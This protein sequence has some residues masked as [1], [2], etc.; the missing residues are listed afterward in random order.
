[1]IH[2]KK[3]FIKKII[4]QSNQISKSFNES[5]NRTKRKKTEFRSMINMNKIIFVVQMKLQSSRK[6]STS[7]T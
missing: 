4:E 6:R 5:N 3:K 2:W 1:M 7:A